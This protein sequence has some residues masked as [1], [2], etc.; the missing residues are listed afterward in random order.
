MAGWG[1]QGRLMGGVFPGTGLNWAEWLTLSWEFGTTLSHS[2]GLRE[3]ASHYSLF[4]SLNFSLSGFMCQPCYG[5][6]DRCEW[7][8]AGAINPASFWVG[9]TCSLSLAALLGEGDS[10]FKSPSAL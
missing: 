1:E 9:V 5:T 7:Q 3:P 8:V 6:K 4:C 2:N 10:D